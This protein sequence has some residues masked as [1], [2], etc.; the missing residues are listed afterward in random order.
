[1]QQNKKSFNEKL[2]ENIDKPNELWNTLKY[3]SMCKKTVL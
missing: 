3:L 2:S 1:M